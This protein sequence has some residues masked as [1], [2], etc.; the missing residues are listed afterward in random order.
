MTNAP[1][2]AMR[3]NPT[4]KAALKELAARLRRSQT[5]TVRFLVNETLM[6]LKEQ[7]TKGKG[8]RLEA[9]HLKRNTH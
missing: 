1:S 4:D 7:E 5:D 6:F 8:G 9:R 3:F 2:L